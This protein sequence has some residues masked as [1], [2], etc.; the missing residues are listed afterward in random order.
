MRAGCSPV[1]MGGK[2]FSRERGRAD[3]LAA[4]GFRLLDLEVGIVELG[5]L[6]MLCGRSWTSDL[7][8][9]IDFCLILCGRTTTSSCESPFVSPFALRPSTISISPDRRNE[10]GD[11]N[12]LEGAVGGDIPGDPN[13][14][15]KTVE[16]KE[17]VEA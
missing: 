11:G 17:G 13:L 5:R 7:V 2:D 1:G 14:G 6:G 8:E 3:P 15:D 10:A 12:K 4:L 9:W 16:G